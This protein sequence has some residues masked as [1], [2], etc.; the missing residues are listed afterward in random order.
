MFLGDQLEIG[1]RIEELR[2]SSFVMAY[3]IERNGEVTAEGTTGLVAFDYGKR[4]VQ[5]LP[6]AFSRAATA[7]EELPPG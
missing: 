3:R 5:R 2:R 1:V 4:K 7:F 6:E